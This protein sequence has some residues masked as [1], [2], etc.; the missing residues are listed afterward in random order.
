MLSKTELR[1]LIRAHNVLSKIT[2]PK[3]ASLEDMEKLVQKAGYKVNHE[4][5][6]LDAQVKRGKQIT[7]KQAEEI[8]KPK[9]KTALQKQKAEEK[10]EEKAIEQKK[11]E[12]EIKKKAIAKEREVQSKKIIKG[13]KDIKDKSLS[14]NRIK[15]KMTA[16]QKLAPAPK[17]APKK[18]R[19]QLKETQKPSTSKVVQPGKPEDVKIDSKKDSSIVERFQK[20]I[21]RVARLK[22]KMD[23]GSQWLNELKFLIKNRKEFPEKYIEEID[24]PFTFNKY[25]KYYK[26]K[27]K[28]YYEDEN[29]F[30]ANSDFTEQLKYFEK[31]EM[32]F[33]KES[34]EIGEKL[35]KEQKEKQ[36]KEQSVKERHAKGDFRVGDKVGFTFPT[37]K[38]IQIDGEVERVNKNSYTI[39]FDETPEIKQAI[40]N[41]TSSG[42]FR[43]YE[44]DGKKIITKTYTA[45]QLQK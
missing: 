13:K 35:E 44:R 43:Y 2:I 5:K 41:K 33:K 42:L 32:K 31:D 23:T 12:R 39:S 40:K 14:I 28:E 17:S 24:I 38:N 6:R 37:D 15:T 34:K 36:A 18:A 29:D 27:L 20:N 1:K 26:D 11:K 10:K 45:K 25:A 19:K 21:L 4:K 16:T 30:P 7:L 3:G 9:P 8:T 22:G